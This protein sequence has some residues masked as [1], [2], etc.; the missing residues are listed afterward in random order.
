MPVHT[1]RYQATQSQARMLKTKV[2]YLLV[3]Q[4]TVD[5]AYS[6]KKG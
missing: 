2:L 6:K 3:E 1:R 4:T 5:P